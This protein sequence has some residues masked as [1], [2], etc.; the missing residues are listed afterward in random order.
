MPLR[1]SAA[2]ACAH[3]AAADPAMARLIE[4][5]GPFTLE[6]RGDAPYVA[7]LR[8]ILYQQL[9]GKAAATIHRRLLDALGDGADDP[10]ALLA[11]DAATIR[12]C[13]VSGGKTAALRDLAAR[14]L[15][16]TVPEGA[17]LDA[18]S[19]DAVVERLVQVRGVGRWTAEMLL[20][21]SLGRPDVWPVDDLGVRKGYTL[22]HGLEALPAPRAL[23]ALGEPYRPFRSVAAWYCWRATELVWPE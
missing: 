3:L 5:A 18:L 9:S 8:S 12:A 14:T 15:D 16:G 17:A 11:L 21:F 7:L 23:A 20:M 13:G 2:D 6:P 1:Y 22:A 19:D 4:R 10:Q